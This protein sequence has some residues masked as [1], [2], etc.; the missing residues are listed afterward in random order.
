M[1]YAV[2]DGACVKVGWTGD[3]DAFSRRLSVLQVGNPNQLAILGLRWGDVEADVH[4]ALEGC[5]IRGE[6]FFDNPMV[7]EVLRGFVLCDSP[8]SGGWEG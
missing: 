3:P 6:W 4:F 7:R 1:T 2:T 8:T 5:A